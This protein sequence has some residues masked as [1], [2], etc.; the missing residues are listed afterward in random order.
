MCARSAACFSWKYCKYPD[1]SGSTAPWRTELLASVTRFA[2]PDAPH[3]KFSG[4]FHS[5]PDY[6]LGTWLPDVVCCSFRAGAALRVTYKRVRFF[7]CT[8]RCWSRN[9]S[10]GRFIVGLMLKLGGLHN[11]CPQPSAS[12]TRLWKSFLTRMNP[13][14]T[15][16]CIHFAHCVG[17]VLT[18]L[19]LKKKKKKV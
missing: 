17:Y 10:S 16:E 15:C 5:G 6:K 18:I 1:I 7:F 19:W 11:V 4:S 14:R 9:C 13:L 3:G 8:T 2:S 12:E